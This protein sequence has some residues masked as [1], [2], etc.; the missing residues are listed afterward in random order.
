MAQPPGQPGPPRAP[1]HPAPYVPEQR[2]RR[3]AGPG[4][5]V[6]L[7]LFMV[8]AAFFLFRCS[9]T[10]FPLWNP[11]A[12]LDAH[13]AKDIGVPL[14]ASA[15]VT[16]GTWQAYVDACH[17]FA[18]EIPP[19]EAKAFVAALG[20]VGSSEPAANPLLGTVGAGRPDWFQ[21]ETLT[22]LQRLDIGHRDQQGG[23]NWYY[24]DG[25]GTL[26]VFWFRT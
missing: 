20:T 23:F 3:K 24:A 17:H 5:L 1:W 11:R 18:I 7:L 10:F 13:L 19:A 26:Y 6:G 14:P 2:A 16:R 9:G 25:S 21:P 15:R 4:F 22:G 12:T 8:P